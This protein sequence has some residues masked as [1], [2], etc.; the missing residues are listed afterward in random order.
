MLATSKDDA[1]YILEILTLEFAGICFI[2]RTKKAKNGTTSRTNLHV[3]SLNFVAQCFAFSV[4]LSR[5]LTL[6][7]NKFT[8]SLTANFA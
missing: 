5:L 1:I 4:E 2:L 6:A 8:Y 3:P 7:Q